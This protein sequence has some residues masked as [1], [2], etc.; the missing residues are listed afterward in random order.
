MTTVLYFVESRYRR[1][2]DG[3]TEWEHL[4]AAKGGSPL[5]YE[6]EDVRAFEAEL[7]WQDECGVWRSEYR[8]RMLPE[9]GYDTFLLRAPQEPCEVI[10]PPLARDCTKAVHELNDTVL[11]ALGL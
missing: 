1:G 5:L 2:R 9:H 10:D 3:W 4:V 8:A 11:T 7:D 6:M